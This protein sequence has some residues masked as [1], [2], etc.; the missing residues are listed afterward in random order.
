MRNVGTQCFKRCF[1]VPPRLNRQHFDAL[2]NQHSSLA[3]NLSTV[4]QV[5][6]RL[7]PFGELYL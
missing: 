5:F 4:L 7:N 1:S 2:G 6:N 3:L